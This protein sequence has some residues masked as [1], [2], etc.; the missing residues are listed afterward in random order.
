[1]RPTSA[2]A[3]LIGADVTALVDLRSGRGG[4]R[5]RD[6]LLEV[7]KFLAAARAELL[8]QHDVLLRLVEL[9]GLDIELAQIFERALVLGVEI[10]RLA[11]ERI[12]LLV[13]AGL[14]QAEAH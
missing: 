4:R 14:A 13:V 7:G 1:M 2:A 10:E 5:L 12:G 11:I 9:P 6:R 3:S 8:E